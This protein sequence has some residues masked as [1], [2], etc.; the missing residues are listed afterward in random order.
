MNKIIAQTTFKFKFSSGK[1][2]TF[3]RGIEY[4]D[5][6]KTQFDELMKLDNRERFFL[7]SEESEDKNKTLYDGKKELI[8]L[9]EALDKRENDLN[10]REA[11]VLELEKMVLS[12]SKT[13]S[14]K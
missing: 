1:N 7:T 9:K 13:N 2:R 10:I 5:L 11:K 14:R 3:I 8:E 6:E 4:I 12:K